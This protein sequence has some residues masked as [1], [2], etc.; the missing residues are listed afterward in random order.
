MSLPKTFRQLEYIQST[1]TQ[2]IRDTVIFN[3]ISVVKIKL[4]EPTNARSENNGIFA[5]STSTWSY[6]CPIVFT[7]VGSLYCYRHESYTP[8]TRNTIIDLE[9][10]KTYF[11]VNGTEYS[12][13]VDSDSGYLE[14]FR[15]YT[16]YGEYKFYSVKVYDSN[17]IIRDFVPAQRKSDSV[18]GLYDLVNDVFYTNAGT[19]TFIAGPVADENTNISKVVYGSDT[20]IDLTLDTVTA[21]SLESGITAHSADGSMIT[22]SLI[23][24]VPI[25]IDNDTDMNS[26]LVAANVGKCYRFT[27]T[28]GTYTNGDLYVVEESE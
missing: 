10:G 9:L 21:L 14:Y 12:T 27:G 25:D 5:T 17:G 19:G 28:T 6:G 26:V 13:T 1:G 2:Y 11:K 15:A 8:V 20:L 18:L 3:D 4:L 24:A 7:H 16:Y 22:G 23:K